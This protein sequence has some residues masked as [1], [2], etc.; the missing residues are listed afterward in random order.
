MPG[1][2]KGKREGVHKYE[3]SIFYGIMQIMDDIAESLRMCCLVDEIRS[4]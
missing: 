1:W 2:K 4:I 3:I